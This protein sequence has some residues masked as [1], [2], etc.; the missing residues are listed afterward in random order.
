MNDVLR[1]INDRDTKAGDLALTP[2]YLAEIIKLVDSGTVNTSTGKSLLEKV[3]DTGKS[4]SQIVVDEG[5]AQV[6]DEDSIR[7]I[8]AEVIDENPEPVASYKGGKTS[9]IGWFVGQVMRKSQGKAD[10][11]MAKA[12]LEELLAK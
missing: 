3:E 12:T 2:E 8:C 5:L 9:I 11:Q 7:V 10:P 1:M 4:P 6:S